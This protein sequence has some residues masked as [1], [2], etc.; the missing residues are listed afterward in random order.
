QID[1]RTSAPIEI[2]AESESLEASF[3]ASIGNCSAIATI[4]IGSP[5]ESKLYSVADARSEVTQPD[6]SLFDFSLSSSSTLTPVVKIVNTNGDVRNHS[7]NFSYDDQAPSI[8]FKAV[9]VT[10]GVD[11]QQLL[12]VALIAT[13]NTDVQYV[14]F[15][16]T[17]LRA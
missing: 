9:S 13:D 11:S 14:G 6:T 10:R 8:Q 3:I 12:N 7:E 1:I 17:G 15:N 4:E 16:V 2:I 5:A